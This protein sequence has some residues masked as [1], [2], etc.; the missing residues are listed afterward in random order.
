MELKP[1]WAALVIAI[2]AYV[3]L[4]IYVA[5]KQSDLLYYPDS[6]PHLP[7]ASPA[8]IGLEYTD[9]TLSTSDGIDLAAWYIASPNAPAT[10]LFC[11]GNAG[12]ISDRLQ[13]LRFF[14]DLGVN[15]LIFDYRGYGESEGTPDEPGT[16][17]D[18]RAAWDYLLESRQLDAAQVVVFGRSLGAAV[19]SHLAT[20][21][22]PA[23]VIL[24]APFV[25]VP[26]VAATF[27]PF[28]PVRLLSRYSYS[29][30]DNVR[31]IASPLLV[32]HSRDDELIPFEHGE[33]VFA[34]A[35]EPKIF[36]AIIGSH[37]GAFARSRAVYRETVEVF[38]TQHVRG[39]NANR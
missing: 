31:H 10:V 16:Y 37:N 2:A 12:S 17:V 20:Q 8:D 25:S 3:V 19:A 15:V 6:P 28:L 27:V 36:L 38:L 13:L 14:H 39:Y 21:V 23:A 29:N 18:V 32:I 5:A 7:D 4:V 26:D 30:L 35:N 22:S 34:A 1:F 33:R 24:E 11:H 9:V